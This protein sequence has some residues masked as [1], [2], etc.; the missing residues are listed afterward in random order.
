MQHY[1]RLLH[2][3]IC[4]VI[5]R[6]SLSGDTHA[7]E[8]HVTLSRLAGRANRRASHVGRMQMVTA[9]PLGTRAIPTHVRTIPG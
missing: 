1:P 8:E 7:W 9:L 6:G 4:R 2:V 5:D 3:L